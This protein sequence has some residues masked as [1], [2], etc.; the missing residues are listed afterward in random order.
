MTK[1]YTDRLKKALINN[2]FITH[3]G[4]FYHMHKRNES[5]DIDFT[6]LGGGWV[7]KYT[8]CYPAKEG[9]SQEICRCSEFF[10]ETL[11]NKRTKNIF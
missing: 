10:N 7:K 3:E 9:W 1:S 5:R 11:G 2:G 4:I 8:R 6:F